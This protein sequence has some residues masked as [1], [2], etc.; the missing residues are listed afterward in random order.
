MSFS[1][2]PRA[3]GAISHRKSFTSIEI[4]FI[5]LSGID[6]FERSIRSVILKN[7]DWIPQ[8]WEVLFL[9]KGF[10]SHSAKSC[11]RFTDLNP[12]KESPETKFADLGAD[13][14]YTVEI[15]MALEEQFGVSLEEGGAE[16]IVT[17]QDATGLIEKVKVAAA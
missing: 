9:G 11:V 15:M 2:I 13:S 8:Q 10:V 3:R 5:L 6:S 14:L 7:A 1:T 17:V 12:T 4:N 16:N